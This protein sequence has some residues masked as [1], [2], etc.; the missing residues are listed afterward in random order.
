MISLCCSDKML[1][2]AVY[3]GGS[4]RNLYTSNFFFLIWKVREYRA[5]YLSIVKITEQGGMK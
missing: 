2:T 3:V 4:N 1:K 5:N